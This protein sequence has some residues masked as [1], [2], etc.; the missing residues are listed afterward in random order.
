[1]RALAADDHAK[2]L[3]EFAE[4]AGQRRPGGRF[5]R[6]RG[7]ESERIAKR[8]DDAP[9]GPPQAWI[10]ADD[11]NRGRHGRTL[12][13]ADGHASDFCEQTGNDRPRRQAVAKAVFRS[14]I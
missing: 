3:M 13:M 9:A 2:A 7:N 5:Q 10:D 14:M 4:P 8:L 1:M 6:A 12:S 11:A